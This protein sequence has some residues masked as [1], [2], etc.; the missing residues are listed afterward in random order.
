MN[1]IFSKMCTQQKIIN[2]SPSNDFSIIFNVTLEGPSREGSGLSMF[3]SSL[4]YIE[5]VKA[6]CLFCLIP[7]PS[8]RI[9]ERKTE[10]RNCLEPKFILQRKCYVSPQ[11]SA[12]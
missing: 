10:C 8:L 2:L 5:W 1:Y 11:N 6:S 9:E 7:S 12:T 4:G 3:P